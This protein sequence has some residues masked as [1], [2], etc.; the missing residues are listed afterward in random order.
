MNCPDA[1]MDYLPTL[2]EK[3]PHSA[4]NAGKK[5]LRGS[6][7]EHLG[8]TM[9]F[10]DFNL[11]IMFPIAYGAV[12]SEGFCWLVE[13]LYCYNTTDRTSPFA[14][15][16]R[17]FCGPKVV[18]SG[19][20][21]WWFQPLKLS[22]CLSNCIIIPK[23][24]GN[25]N[26]KVS[27]HHTNAHPNVFLGWF[28]WSCWR[29]PKRQHHLDQPAQDSI[30]TIRINLPKMTT[31]LPRLHPANIQRIITKDPVFLWSFPSFLGHQSQSAAH[32]AMFPPIPAAKRSQIFQNMGW[33]TR[34]N[35]VTHRIHLWYI[36]L[37]LVDL[38]GKWVVGKFT[39]LFIHGY[40][41]L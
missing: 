18:C 5:Y 1:C 37:H 24:R 6:Y 16:V 39:I 15:H 32:S 31:H 34:K 30:V 36:Y 9:Y 29:Q 11:W 38:E 19:R 10:S 20:G 8:Y 21:W 14:A 4:G 26:K 28:Y 17:S 23:L 7:M 2:V 41:G 3:W 12:P 40:Y 13:F 35:A 27:N 22:I 25:K 33:K